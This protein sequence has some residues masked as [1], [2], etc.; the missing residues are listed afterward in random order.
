MVNLT[1]I[2]KD[3]L[4][5]PLNDL[6]VL[7]ILGVVIV[8]STFVTSFF[9]LYNP[10]LAVEVVGLIISVM[11]SLVVVG[12]FLTVIKESA[13]LSDIIP[14][15]DSK[16]NLIGG[17]KVLILS[18]IYVFV[19]FFIIS[20]V[21]LISG[22]ISGV[23]NIMVAMINAASVAGP[24]SAEVFRTY[25]ANDPAVSQ[26]ISNSITGITITILVGMILAIIFTIVFNISL[27]RLA[28]YDSIS[29]AVEIKD[30]FKDISKIGIGKYSGW[31]VLFVILFIIMFIIAC[32]LDMVF[33]FAGSIGFI[34]YTIIFELVLKTYFILFSARSLGLLYSC[35]DKE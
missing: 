19:Y 22:A 6:K 18:I 3:S 28:K 34:I 20:V 26:A 13:E 11:I 7:L 1:R 12:Y 8:A 2:F 32:I 23:N 15:F 24:S 31:I 16:K 30:V 5:Y 14:K 10:H 33:S 21:A 27:C 35:V 25:V 17:L 29:E 9:D 4:K